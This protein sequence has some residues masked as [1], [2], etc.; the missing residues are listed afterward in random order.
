MKRDILFAAI[1]TSVI[2]QAGLAEHEVYPE[3]K[4]PSEEQMKLDVQI[5][6]LG[7]MR[8]LLL[9]DPQ[10]MPIEK[11]IA[12][13]LT[14]VDFR[15]FPS[16]QAVEERVSSAQMREIGTENKADLVLY[17]TASVRQK[18]SM[19]EFQ[20]FEGEATAQIF[21]PVSGEMFV[22]QTNRALGTRSVDE[23]EA[24][25]SAVEKAVD[26]ATQEAINRGLKKVYKTIVHRA[27]VTN[28][29]DYD[30]VLIIIAY[31]E[32]MKGIYHVR[33]LS[34]DP[35]THVLELEI[36]GAPRAESEWRAYLDR[37][38]RTRVVVK[39]KPIPEVHR[40][41]KQYPSWFHPS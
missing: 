12:Q 22:S 30:R 32:K 28:V 16:A 38:P 9:L 18:N 21:S 34:F 5:T 2:A 1:L 7:T 8:T 6:E 24:Q 41:G 23:V 35:K 13:R 10:A 37:M 27:I 29:K 15:V 40:G 33:Q 4:V 19:G 31:M 14:E 36:I 25:R 39:V 20:L 11:L 17:A 3:K 26:E